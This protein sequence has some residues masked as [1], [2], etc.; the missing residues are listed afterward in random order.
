M[1]NGEPNQ[2]EDQQEALKNAFRK[3]V[4]NIMYVI[5][6]MFTRIMSYHVISYHIYHIISYHSCHVMS[7]M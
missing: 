5:Y 3:M 6:V 7:C 4:R 2:N 1:D